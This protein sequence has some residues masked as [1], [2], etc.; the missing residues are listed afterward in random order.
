MKIAID[1][2]FVPDQEAALK[3]YTE[4]LGFQKK[5]DFPVGKYKWLT[6]VSPEQPDGPELLLEPDE[7][8]AAKAF[9]KALM[10]DGIPFRVFGVDDVQQEYE[11]L[12]SLGVK[13]TMKPHKMGPATIAVF[14]DSCGNLIQIAQKD[15]SRS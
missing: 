12:T 2:V 6:V 14:D 10:Q 4:V 13:F 1:S 8:P 15:E 11:R 3:F 5:H 9:K 7:H